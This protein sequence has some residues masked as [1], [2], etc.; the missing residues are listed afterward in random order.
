M[1]QTARP[2][3]TRPSDTWAPQYFLASVGAGGIAVAFFLW[4]FMWVPHPG[5]TVPIF[6]DIATAWAKGNVLMNAMIVT[7]MTAIAAFGFLNLKM[8]AWNLPRSAAF[9]SS[10]AMDKLRTTNGESQLVNL[11]LA[12][13]MSINVLFVLGLVFV[14]GLWNVVEYLFPL[15]MAAFLTVGALALAITGR[16]YARVFGQGGLDWA[17]N[18]SFAQVQPAFALAMVSVGLGAAA[19]MSSNPV[20]AG[21]AVVAATILSVV[22]FLIAIV[23]V[24]LGFVSMAQHGVAKETAPSLTIIV[25]LTTVLGILLLRI[26]HGLDTHFGSHMANGDY[27]FLLSSLIGVQVAFLLL[28]ATVLRAQGYFGRFVTGPEV[29]AGSYGLVCPGVAFAVMLQF[30]I[31][32]GLVAAGIIAKFGTVYWVI[33]GLSV[34]ALLATV[35]LML[36]L[37]RKHFGAVKTR[38]VAAE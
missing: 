38:V 34:A 3:D 13:A 36:V 7:A 35:G 20:T 16:F 21:V 23:A 37:N 10:P 9:K 27:L 19:A 18:N 1:S 14:P 33:S 2:S 17:A 28:G 12:L 24:I 25:P 5:Q 31:N 22:A 15:A 11:P 8:L 6:E 29:S 30:F 4:L 26:N 32:K